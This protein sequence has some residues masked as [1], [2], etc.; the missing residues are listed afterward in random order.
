MLFGWVYMSLT[1]LFV[2]RCMCLPL[3]LSLL[4]Q[5]SRTSGILISLRLLGMRTPKRVCT[6]AVP[7]A[8]MSN[9]LQRASYGALV[10]KDFDLIS[11]L[12]PTPSSSCCATHYI[13]VLPC[14]GLRSLRSLRNR[15]GEQVA[16]VR[17][18]AAVSERQ[19][20]PRTSQTNSNN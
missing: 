16:I 10:W 4:L 13:D 19:G 11:H 2:Y 7:R 1:W 5:A 3:C 15:V 6:G 14:S 8:A 17:C 12:C 18:I 9:F 20:R